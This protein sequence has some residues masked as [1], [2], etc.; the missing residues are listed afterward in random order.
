M[1]QVSGKVPQDECKLDPLFTLPENSLE[2]SHALRSLRN[3]VQSSSLSIL[4][5]SEHSNNQS[6]LSKHD[7]VT[8]KVRHRFELTSKLISRI[9]RALEARLLASFLAI[10]NQGGIYDFSTKSDFRNGRLDWP[11][12]KKLAEGLFCFDGGRN[13]QNQYVNQVVASR[14][15]EFTRKVRGDQNK[16]ESQ[17]DDEEDYDMERTR[18]TLSTLFHRVAE[19]CSAEFALIAHVFNFSEYKLVGSNSDKSREGKNSASAE[20]RPLQVARALLY[21][22]VSDNNRGGLQTCINDL[23]SSIKG[24]SAYDIGTKK[25]DTVIVIHEKVSGLFT[26]LRDAME[27][28][29]IVKKVQSISNNKHFTDAPS[30]MSMASS[31]L[32]HFLNSQEIAL[33]KG[34][35]QSYLN[36]ELRKWNVYKRFIQ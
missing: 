8:L 3:V 23:L 18:S 28:Y 34:N 14:F 15:P 10:Y 21:R 19:V 35:R 33:S 5:T 7:N 30:K 26:L 2:A 32:V 17:F 9:S 6:S 20:T 13:I 25:L 16:G 1:S 29:L 24:T 22:I 12:L 36:L 31:A 4:T 27:R 11:T